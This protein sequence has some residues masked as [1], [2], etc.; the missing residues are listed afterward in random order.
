MP[1]SKRTTIDVGTCIDDRQGRDQREAN[2]QEFNSAGVVIAI[3]GQQERRY[4]E[5]DRH[6]RNVDQGD[7]PPVEMLEQH[8]ADKRTNETR[9]KQPV[10][11]R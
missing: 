10:L 3:F 1:L 5:H 7:R 8:A 4:R 9:A 2:A 11:R 6:H